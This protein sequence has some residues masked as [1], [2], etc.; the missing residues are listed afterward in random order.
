MI[1]FKN[2]NKWFDQV[3]ILK[4]INLK[5]KSGEVVVVC[6]PSGSGKSTLLRTIN[7]L[8]SIQEGEIVVNGQSLSDPKL[9]LPRFR[10]EIGMIFQQ[11]NLYPHKNALQN[12]MLAPVKV[13][14][15]NQKEAKSK[16]LELLEKVGLAGRG[17]AFP[18][19]LSGGEQQRVAIARSLAMEPKIMLFDEATSALDPELI[20][21]VLDVMMSLAQ[22]GMTMMVVTHEMG[23]ARRVADRIFFL[24]KGEILES[25]SPTDI[26]V[27]P[28]HERTRE[29]ISEI[30]PEASTLLKIKRF[31][32]MR[33]GMGYKS[34]P[35][36]HLN[37]DGI[38]SGFDVEFA[39]EIAKKLK[40]SPILIKSA[41]KDRISALLQ[42]SVDISISNLNHTITREQAID[43][44]QPYLCDKKVFLVKKGRFKAIDEL[45][46]KAVGVVH[47]SNAD[48]DVK[49]RFGEINEKTPGF[50]Y[51]ESD[52]ECLKAMENENIDAYVN[53]T[54]LVRGAI[55]GREGYEFLGEPFSNTFFS[56]GIMKNDAELRDEI[57]HVIRDMWIDGTYM[58]LF[59][60]YFGEKS[61]YPLPKES[62]KFNIFAE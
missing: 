29:F 21:D 51:Y 11:F 37:G 28:K 4:N 7:K 50:V 19:H 20:N 6:G 42:N 32:R 26:F 43:F 18:C 30:L 54:I 36:N 25:G 22:E 13:R 59:D 15:L 53:D 41:G 52:E 60:K 9:N 5:I 12:I 48:T 31:K 35:L 14:K 17:E 23:F 49:N 1:E 61:N 10:T 40:V 56:V 62:V 47:G 46:G 2:V 38:W 3:Q 33:I 8:E 45:A 55:A 58:R 16:A 34:K 44:S 27:R 57:N 24:D 39:K